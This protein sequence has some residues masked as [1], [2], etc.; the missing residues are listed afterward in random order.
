MGNRNFLIRLIG[1]NTLILAIVF[2]TFYSVYNF[3]D[4]KLKNI[5]DQRH[6]TILFYNAF[7]DVASNLYQSAMLD[8]ADY[9]TNAAV[10]S[11]CALQLLEKIEKNKFV[12]RTLRQDYNDFFRYTVMTTSLSLEHRLKE[13]RVANTI[14]QQKHQKLSAALKFIRSSVEEEQNRIIKMIETFMMISSVL[15]IVV[16]IINIRLLSRSAYLIRTKESEQAE[17][18]NALGDGVYGVD[19]QGNCT[20]INRSAL[21]MLKFTEKE[22]LGEDQHQLFHHHHLDKTLYSDN[23][24]PIHHTIIDRQIRHVRETFI[25]KDGSFFPV[26]VTV[27]PVG[28]ASG[29][30]V[31][32]DITTLQE[33]HAML[34]RFANYDNLTGLPNRR[35]FMI[36]ANQKIA[37]SDRNNDVMAVAFLDLDGF[38]Q[39]NDLYGHEMGDKLLQEVAMRCEEALRKSDIVARFGGDEFVILLDFVHSSNEAEEIL[40]RVIDEITRPFFIDSATLQIGVSIGYTLF[41]EDDSNLNILLQHADNA[42]YVAKESGKGILKRFSL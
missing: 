19:K 41:P 9:L 32:Q 20:F 16:V 2:G 21:D 35:L 27:A 8:D 14:S 42:M 13:A 3:L 18:I 25:R 24:C 4:T 36:L 15:L 30:V 26:S 33:E 31:F 11:N 28:E 1:A 22:V 10:S 7:N 17:M 39:V 23:E 5:M 6:T 29:I 38:K 34:D 12:T 37:Q 40:S